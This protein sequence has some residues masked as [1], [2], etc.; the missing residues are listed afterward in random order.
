MLEHGADL[1]AGD[2]WGK[3]ITPLHVAAA[4][5]RGDGAIKA[6]RVGQPPALAKSNSQALEKV[7]LLVRAGANVAAR[8][9]D[10]STPLLQAALAGNEDIC[11][12]LMD[13][14]AKLDIG[15][16]CLLGK[17]ATV[18]NLLEQSPDLAFNSDLPLGQSALH[19]AVRADDI[20]TVRMLVGIGA[21][22][23]TRAPELEYQDA[24]GFSAGSYGDALG[25]TALNLAVQLGHERVVA[26]L[27]DL[28]ADPNLKV[29]DDLIDIAMADNHW[30]IVRLLLDHDA[31]V[32]LSY[33]VQ[34]G[35][36]AM[37][38]VSL[39][40][41]VIEAVDDDFSESPGTD[42]LRVAF[43]KKNKVTSDLLIAHGAQIDFHLACEFGFIDKAK[44]MLE[45]DPELA[46]IVPANYS[47][48]SPIELAVRNGSQA[49]VQLLIDYGAPLS[50]DNHRGKSLGHLAA[51]EGQL[52]VL[53]VLLSHGLPIDVKNDGGSTLLHAAASGV[54]PEVA[55]FLISQGLEVNCRDF[56]GSTPLHNV[57]GWSLLWNEDER[58]EKYQRTLETAR[59]LLDAGAEVN[60]KDKYDDRP[61]H[62]A[63]RDELE[64]VVRLFLN[65]GADVNARDYRN[66]T[67]LAVAGRTPFS[68]SF[69]SQP[70][71]IEK[72]LREHGGIE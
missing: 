7:S 41:R 71:S 60:A 30:G 53:R 37:T 31:E 20:E 55:R 25:L 44:R 6:H 9:K 26:T 47:D 51:S 48:V 72:L 63:A 14:G 34:D 11:Q 46:K 1:I 59:V 3:G 40:R 29:D 10:L 56:R 27:L 58:E 50:S 18:A 61:L 2:S 36:S 16:A 65:R 52:E 23:D 5:G 49:I 13:N 8:A 12:L 69:Q 21:N 39:L 28:G 68:R 17:R 35:L 67:P 33:G 24:G 22:V 15:S 64:D 66:Q 62:K 54:Q 45:K 38:D 43:I 32:S 4:L 42:A 19:Y 70:K 57:A